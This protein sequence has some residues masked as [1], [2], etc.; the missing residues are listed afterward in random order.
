VRRQSVSGVEMSVWVRH[1]AALSEHTVSYPARTFHQPR[2]SDQ[3]LVITSHFQ[4]EASWRQ[5]VRQSHI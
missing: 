4:P 2:S 5:D 1:A 3:V